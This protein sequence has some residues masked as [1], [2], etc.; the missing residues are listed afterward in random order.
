MGGVSLRAAMPSNAGTLGALKGDAMGQTVM[1]VTDDAGMFITVV[2][3]C[4]SRRYRPANNI[5]R[6]RTVHRT[7][8][9]NMVSTSNL[10]A[11][12]NF[13]GEKV[14]P[15]VRVPT[16]CQ[17]NNRPPFTLHKWDKNYH[18]SRPACTLFQDN[19]PVQ[20]CEH[21]QQMTGSLAAPYKTVLKVQTVPSAEEDLARPT[22]PSHP[23]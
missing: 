15:L 10:E 4:Y 17:G 22:T 11:T 16:S 8:L 3:V 5:H 9:G 1:F 12:R 7:R 18:Y 6:L 19:Y 13:D 14:Y 21:I 2:V 23:I 20:T